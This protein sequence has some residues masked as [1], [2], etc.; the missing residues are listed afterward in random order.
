ML[1][2]MILIGFHGSQMNTKTKN[3]VDEKYRIKN[4]M[5]ELVPAR[6]WMEY[7][8]KGTLLCY[9]DLTEKQK[10]EADHLISSMNTLAMRIQEVQSLA[11]SQ[12]NNK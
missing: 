9:S 4:G 2:L 3:S 7:R 1:I 6:Y 12:R 10:I 8:S 11:M 5:L